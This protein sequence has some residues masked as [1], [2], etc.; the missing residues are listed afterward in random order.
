MASK[1]LNVD[2]DNTL[3]GNSASDTKVASQKAIKDYV[4]LTVQKKQDKLIAGKNI[5]LLDNYTVLDY[6]E[7]TGTQCINTNI[8]DHKLR[9]EILGQITD[10]AQTALTILF[11]WGSNRGM[12]IVAHPDGGW[13][14]CA[15]GTSV[16]DSSLLTELVYDYTATQAT[17]TANGIPVYT[18]TPTESNNFAAH[19]FC[20]LIPTGQMRYFSTGRIY[21]AKATNSVGDLVAN[22][23]PVKRNSDNVV[24]MYDTVTKTF[25]GNSGTGAFI[26][27]SEAHKTIIESADFQKELIAGTNI[28]ID[29]EYT[30]LEYIEST[31]TQYIDT[32]I[33]AVGASSYGAEL[34]YAYPSAQTGRSLIGAWEGDGYS[35]FGQPFTESGLLSALYIG[36]PN[37]R[38]NAFA[39]TAGTIITDSFSVNVSGGSVTRTFNGATSTDSS[40]DFSSPTT[41]TCYL[42]AVHRGGGAQQISSARMYYA[43]LYKNNVLVFDG[44]PVKRNIDNVVGMYDT[45]TKTFFGNSGSGTFIAG[46]VDNKQINSNKQVISADL[47]NS[48]NTDLSNLTSTGKNI[49]LWC[50]NAANIITEI[51][52]DINL[53]I[54]DDNGTKKL[55]LK[56]G[57]KVY[58]PAGSGTFNT[59]T[60]TTDIVCQGTDGT[61]TTMVFYRMDGQVWGNTRLSDCNSGTTTPNFGMFYNTST[62]KVNFYNNGV[63]ADA[64]DFSF[65]IAIITF[66]SGNVLSIDQVFNG[67]GYIGSTAFALPGVKGLAPNGRNAD[68]TLKNRTISITQVSTTTDVSGTTGGLW[69]TIDNNNITRVNF[70]VYEYDKESNY[71]IATSSLAKAGFVIIDEDAYRTTG[72]ITSFRPKQVFRALDYSD[73]EFIAHCAM[74]S[75][76]WFYLSLSGSGTTYTAPADGYVVIRRRA[77]AA[78]NALEIMNLNSSVG[79]RIFANAA[80]QMQSVFVPVAKGNNFAVAYDGTNTSD[81]EFKFAY[82]QGAK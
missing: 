5:E 27:G 64:N 66:S 34:K 56:A 15:D 48:A 59:V 22:F 24:G 32:G 81:Q 52:Q 49:G 54:F 36:K 58:V 62:N 17:L 38:T 68:G 69:Y 61:A 4:D 74:P 10:P 2:I 41:L 7:T 19:L 16:G 42:F 39:Y 75:T 51:P 76:N 55:R 73:T 37:T 57:S 82:T 21:S 14:N 12:C 13:E 65:P 28:K 79:M 9:W 23:I 60:T 70:G 1:F 40:L 25:F 31:G 29:S 47:S 20:G 11:G 30:A 80:N 45:V 46:P 77:S 43:K 71:F 67:F 35:A 6:I 72:N 63:I 78:G 53:E 3:G 18:Y 50:N 8:T 33:N 26:A 44:V